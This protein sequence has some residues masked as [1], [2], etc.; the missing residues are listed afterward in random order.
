MNR[1]DLADL[2]LGERIGLGGQGTVFPVSNRKINGIWDVV[3][4]E[5]N[6]V[7]S[8]VQVAALTERADLVLE[9]PATTGIW[10]CEKT[11]WPAATV[12]SGGRVTG[13][14]MRAIPDRFYFDLTNLGTSGTTRKPATWRVIQKPSR[15]DGRHQIALA[16]GVR[17]QG[18]D[19]VRFIVLTAP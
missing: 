19:E 7:L 6:D 17:Q 5:Y 16:D 8:N 9:L 1:V 14:L 11:A 13:F 10:L 18:V 4:K 15:S 2:A 3:Y 12:E